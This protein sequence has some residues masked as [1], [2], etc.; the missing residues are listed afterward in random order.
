MTKVENLKEQWKTCNDD[1][2]VAIVRQILEIENPLHNKTIVCNHDKYGINKSIIEAPYDYELY[3][4][5]KWSGR[6]IGKYSDKNDNEA[7]KDMFKN[8]FAIVYKDYIESEEI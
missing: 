2:R 6:I 7:L 1:E 8:G 4:S 3:E 5:G